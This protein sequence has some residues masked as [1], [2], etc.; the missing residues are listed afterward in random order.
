MAEMIPELHDVGK[1]LGLQKH[2]FD[3]MNRPDFVP[4]DSEETWL[5]IRF[6][7]YHGGMSQSDRAEFNRLRQLNAQGTGIARK[8]L[9][10][11]LAD[12]A[13]ASSRVT[14]GRGIQGYFPIDTPRLRL[15]RD[16]SFPSLVTRDEANHSPER[17][18][19]SPTQVEI[20]DLIR[21]AVNSSDWESFKDSHSEVLADI[22]EDKNPARCMTSLATHSELTGKVYRL[23]ESQ[24]VSIAG[25]AS[26]KLRLGNV[27]ANNQATARREWNLYILR[28]DV[29][30]PQ[31]VAHARDVSIFAAVE[32]AIERIRTGE[33]RDHILFTASQTLW[34]ILLPGQEDRLSQILRPFLDL[35]VVI[36]VVQRQS[37]FNEVAFP[38]T[39]DLRAAND[40]S[41]AF[42]SLAEFPE[43]VGE[44]ICELCQ[45]REGEPQSPDP[46]SGVVEV[47]CPTCLA[48]RN[49]APG[50]HNLAEWD[51]GPVLWCRVVLD[52]QTLPDHLN[53]LYQCY[54]GNLRYEN[55]QRVVDDA[56]LSELAQSFQPAALLAE[57]ADDYRQF[58]SDFWRRLERTLDSLG[59]DRQSS[60]EQIIRRADG[61]SDLFAI[62]L[63]KCGVPDGILN[64]FSEALQE[65]FPKSAK[66]D[67]CPIRIG[68]SL[69]HAKHPFFLH[70][71][72]LRDLEKTV[73]LFS[74]ARRPVCLSLDALRTVR[75][76]A[77]N[78]GRSYLYN[79]AQIERR[80]Q[81]RL[82]VEVK[83]I[84][85]GKHGLLEVARNVGL[86]NVLGYQ[87]VIGAGGE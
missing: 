6:H 21:D 41:H 87:A 51:E 12:W 79:L 61:S 73:N 74:P 25:S 32:D 19:G 28:A 59:L 82:M 27:D 75:E 78:L 44:Q 46:D 47:L 23:L 39:D 56:M 81:S 38:L 3:A 80:T 84:S 48:I 58:I 62:K 86:E 5:A 17:V 33:Y 55:G 22:P 63:D 54:L 72:R 71:D 69:S 24:V 15:W 65:W 57:Y 4:P 40:C 8:L 68:L 20:D 10:L 11:S 13:A 67:D 35:G 14:P 42:P 52:G 60:V 2:W 26:G 83:L 37:R 66:R 43:E 70:W 49:P 9:L 77:D 34:L 76:I 1:L 36:S 85:D 18:H 45:I 30:I 53:Q 29:T 7:N 50:F 16:G 64:A 31:R